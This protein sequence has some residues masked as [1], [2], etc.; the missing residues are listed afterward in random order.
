MYIHPQTQAFLDML[1]AG[2]KDNPPPATMA[3][4]RQA[5]SGLWQ[6]MAAP[7]PG[8][9]EC[10]SHNLTLDGRAVEALV[11]R[12]TA[13]G[14]PLPILIFYHGGGCA[15]LSPED[16]DA[17]SRSLAL[18]AHCIVVVP[19]F[20]QAP[21]HP[22]PAPLEDSFL[23]YRWLLSH[24]ADLGGD[25]RLAI[26][27]DSGGGY[28]AAAVA[29]EAKRHGLAQPAVQIL[30]YPMLDMASA[31]PSRYT[32]AYFVTDAAL[33][34]VIALHV[35]DQVLDPRASPL[36][37]PDLAGLAPAVVIS[38]D[39]DPLMDEARAYVDRLRA[40][41]VDASY[42]VYEGMVHGFFSFGGRI[43]EGNDAVQHVAGA[44]RA[45]F[46]RAR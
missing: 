23:A 20:R 35:G 40:A 26:A 39:L 11:Y 1:A 14:G 36:R 27:G 12:P 5:F 15:T 38:T 45:R 46:R 21:E 42:F 34:G 44:L 16:F 10:Q 3:E 28:L 19:R 13:A 6:A 29:Q 18:D 9:V 30:I 22:F 24:G 33:K 17:T 32:K 2:A 25:G 41:G 31:A 8:G 7:L 43:D 37:E 4:Q